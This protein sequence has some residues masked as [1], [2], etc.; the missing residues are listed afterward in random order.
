MDWQINWR[1]LGEDSE[2]SL[3][4]IFEIF[5]GF[6]GPVWKCRFGDFFLSVR[7]LSGLNPLF[8]GRWVVVLYFFER[9]FNGRS[10]LY[11]N[12]SYTNHVFISYTLK[13][14]YWIHVFEKTHY[15]EER[16]YFLD[17]LLFCT[18]KNMGRKGRF[19]HVHN[20][21]EV[22]KQIYITKF[23]I[24]ITIILLN[25]YIHNKLYTSIRKKRQ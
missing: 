16:I 15:V 1:S 13:P 4:N 7:V 20:P 25:L 2:L 14:F 23:Q 19:N 10:L 6:Q 24:L 5:R 21:S 8:S 3:P 22:E 9:S 12:H 18:L 11:A 17:Y